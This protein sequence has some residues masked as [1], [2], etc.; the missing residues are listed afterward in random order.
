[1]LSAA[2]RKRDLYKIKRVNPLLEDNW[3]YNWE[4]TNRI[5]IILKSKRITKNKNRIK[6]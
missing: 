3:C 2:A 6:E 1:M 4:N 5:E